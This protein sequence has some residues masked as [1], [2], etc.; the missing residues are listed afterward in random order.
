MAGARVEQ[1]GLARPVGPDQPSDGGLRGRQR[2]SVEGQAT[3]EPNRDVARLEATHDALRRR[4]RSGLRPARAAVRRGS[5]RRSLSPR[6]GQ[7]VTT[8]AA[9][10][11]T[12]GTY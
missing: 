1:R 6:A 11:K 7:T 9:R 10:P 2:H 8:K 4:A 5:K 3:S 12:T